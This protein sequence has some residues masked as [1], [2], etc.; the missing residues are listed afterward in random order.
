MAIRTAIASGNWNDSLT[1]TGGLIPLTGDEVRSNGFTVVIDTDLSTFT[2]LDINN[3]GGGGFTCAIPCTI[4]S[5]ITNL[6]VGTPLTTTHTAGTLVTINGNIT[7]SLAASHRVG[8]THSGTGELRIN[9]KITGAN[10]TGRNY[11]DG[12]RITNTSLV[13]V[14]GN[15]GVIGGGG[16]Y[17]GAAINVS[18]VGCTLK[19]IG[20]VTTS[21]GNGGVGIYSTGVGADISVTGNVTSALTGSSGYGIGLYAITTLLVIGNI[22]SQNSRCIYSTLNCDVTVMGTISTQSPPLS[23]VEAI[24]L[25]AGLLKVSGYIINSTSLLSVYAN[26]MR[27]ISGSPTTWTFINEL[28]GTKN[29]YTADIPVLGNPNVGN[30]RYG[31]TFGP[32]GELTGTMHIPTPDTVLKGVPV[33]NTVGTA[34]MTPSDFWDHPLALIV[35]PDSIGVRVKDC[36]TVDST[37]KQIE[38]LVP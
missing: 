27:L 31:T 36:S 33:D 37:G 38:K 29:L 5:N 20:D 3:T 23:V 22:K 19:V 1:W 16:G 11:C 8:M 12:L 9:G 21:I 18:G 14:T 2:F 17:A 28:A 34:I 7:A 4:N 15:C 26:R 24:Y 32:I 6:G 13:I 35:A 30:V 10:Q 25:P